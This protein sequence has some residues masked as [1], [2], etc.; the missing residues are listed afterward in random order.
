MTVRQLLFKCA[1][2]ELFVTTLFTYAVE[3]GAKPKM[4]N[5]YNGK[6]Q[7]LSPEE[8][9]ALEADKLRKKQADRASSDAAVPKI[10]SPNTSND[11]VFF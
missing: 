11:S 2:F 10:V 4:W 6:W 8:E 1:T 7:Q 9:V 3:V 5:K